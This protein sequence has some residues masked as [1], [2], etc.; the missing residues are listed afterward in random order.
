M[1]FTYRVLWCDD[2]DSWFG[3]IRSLAEIEIEAATGL[4]PEIKYVPSLEKALYED[5][6]FYDLFLVDYNLDELDRANR[7]NQGEKLIGALRE[8]KVF[9]TVIFYSSNDIEALRDAIHGDKLDGVYVTS[10]RNTALL[11]MLASVSVMSI[12]KM[13]DMHNIRGLFLSGV[14]DVEYSMLENLSLACERF[15]GAEEAKETCEYYVTD[16]HNQITKK[17]AEI[18]SVKDIIKLVHLYEFDLHRKARFIQRFLRKISADSPSSE[19]AEKL[20]EMGGNYVSVFKS[21]ISSLRNIMAHNDVDEFENEM[22]SRMGMER[23]QISKLDYL[24]EIRRRI[25]KHQEVMAIM[26]KFL[27]N[28]D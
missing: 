20:R 18:L 21:D 26:R 27:K 24:R 28:E 4:H 8:N 16:I 13:L 9:T 7:E 11:P 14:V 6:A 19:V 10:R 2:D 1:D 25:E 15:L 3:S 22:L 23:G 5:L 17:D 12:N